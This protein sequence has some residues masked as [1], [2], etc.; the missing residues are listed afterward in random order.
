MGSDAAWGGSRAARRFEGTAAEAQGE[1]GEGRGK[2]RQAY[3]GAYSLLRRVRA[4]R[5]EIVCP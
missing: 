1:R 5:R 4:Q 2:T 3:H